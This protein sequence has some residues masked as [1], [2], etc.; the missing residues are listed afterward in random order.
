MTLP[1]PNLRREVEE[2]RHP[3]GV[4]KVISGG[5]SSRRAA[6]YTVTS[7]THACGKY[8]SFKP[9]LAN[10]I[11]SLLERVFY[12]SIN[13][14]YV[15]PSVPDRTYVFTTL[16]TAAKV[17][18][19]YS[20]ASTPVTVEKFPEYYWGRR[21]A[22][23][24]RAAAEVLRFGF[25]ANSARIS[26][27]G[28]VEKILDAPKRL[29]MRVI[30]PRRPEY[31]VSLG[32]FLRPIEHTIYENISRMFQPTSSHPTPVVAKGLNALQ[33][34]AALKAH[35]DRIALSG[36]VVAL[37]LDASRWD[38]HVSVPL[39]QWEHLRYLKYYPY[40]RKELAKILSCQLKCNGTMRCSDGLI[41]YS[42]DGGRMSGDI[43][44]ALGNVVLMCCILYAMIDSLHIPLHEIT[45]FN[46]GDDVSL[47]M[48]QKWLSIITSAVNSWFDK[49]GH[50]MKVESPVYRLEH[51]E[52]CQT[53]PV[54]LAPDKWIMVRN[55]PA[56][57][58]K[59]L[60]FTTSIP[61]DNY[62]RCYIRTIGEAGLALGSGVPILQEFYSWCVKASNRS[63]SSEQCDIG[64][65]FRM[66]A[67]GMAS[68][69]V[70]ITDTARESFYYAFGM[71][72][73]VQIALE[74]TIAGLSV[75][76]FSQCDSETL[77]GLAP[78]L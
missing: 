5:L 60:T 44:T 16:K 32:R 42:V 67:R 37:G 73:D 77:K 25:K 33:T 3:R 10:G 9:N 2:G 47:I 75:P 72:P 58:A 28:K 22:L 54:Q 43:N 63:L 52:F 76:E 29:V 18:D 59:D 49:F 19:S 62:L 64:Y 23:Y 30:Q 36:P 1:N 39:L 24:T 68:S 70:P 17:L 4:M 65:G 51:I 11:T 34:G 40:D 48:N 35:W 61:D 12:H 38:Q 41:R 26:A 74:Q 69:Y 15:I 66:M 46:N 71:L 7:L 55:Y 45:L 6:V 13:G 21:K 56:C 8:L 78:T 57:L 50:V 53:H 20:R 27:F 14:E 31:N